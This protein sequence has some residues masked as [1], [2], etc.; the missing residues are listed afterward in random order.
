[1]G[2]KNNPGNFDCYQNAL[3]DEPMF[4]LLAH[5]PEFA[6]IVRKWAMKRHNDIACGERPLSDIDM[7]DEAYKCADDGAKWRRL[8]Y[9]KWRN[10]QS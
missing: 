9:G 5:D 7:V 6:E 4:I 2:T 1:M 8:N 3:P 10:A